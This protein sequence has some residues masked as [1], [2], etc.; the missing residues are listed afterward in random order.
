[1]TV[2]QKIAL[3]RRLRWKSTRREWGGSGVLLSCEMLEVATNTRPK[4]ARSPVR[5]SSLFSSHVAEEAL[6]A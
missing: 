6:V 5:G 3:C 4:K 1:M 2:N